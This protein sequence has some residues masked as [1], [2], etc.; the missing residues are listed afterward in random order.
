MNRRLETLL[1]P[2]LPRSL[3]A[4]KSG[5]WRR[6]VFSSVFSVEINALEDVMKA[7]P[8]PS[9]LPQEREKKF[10]TLVPRAAVASLLCPRLPYFAPPGL[11]SSH[12]GMVAAM[13]N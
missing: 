1:S 12:G 10:G 7:R 6:M 3:K 11:R 8:L 13:Y 2:A 4:R 5:G 9:P